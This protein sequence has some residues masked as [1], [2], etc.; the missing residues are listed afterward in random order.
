MQVW[1]VYRKYCKGF[2]SVVDFCQPF[3]IRLFS[4][5]K[6]KKFFSGKPVVASLFFIVDFRCCNQYGS[7]LPDWDKTFNTA[8]RFTFLSTFY[9]KFLLFNGNIGSGKKSK[10]FCLRN[11]LPF[12]IVCYPSYAVFFF[13]G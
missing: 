4:D 12:G 3:F 6:R 9:G 2:R 11:D 7:V 10:V 1:V 5:S 8:V 13:P